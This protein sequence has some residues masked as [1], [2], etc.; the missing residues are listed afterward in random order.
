M[1][2]L[3]KAALMIW[4][5]IAPGC[6]ADYEEWHSKEH[7]SE[8]V[9]IPGFVRGHRGRAISGSPRYINWYEVDEL[10]V[11]TSK[12]Y[13]DRLN[14]PTPWTRKALGYFRDNNRTLCRVAASVGNG[15]SGHL[16]SVQ[17][18]A[19]P[20]RSAELAEWLSASMAGLLERSGIIGAHYLEGDIE[21]SQVDT[22]EKRLREGHDAV[23]DRVVLI[24]GYNANALQ[25]L[26]G[27]ALSSTALQNHGAQHGDRAT[28]YQLL[29]S[30]TRVDL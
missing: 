20:G 27:D 10:T 12:A 3:G 15:V 17:L 7:M 25:D 28:V 21:A 1:S 23:T 6:E 13:L 14:D 11:L 24:A 9:A 8:R 5:D 30:I 22:E 16:L 19:Q 26:R 4:H 29:H 2:L 18:A